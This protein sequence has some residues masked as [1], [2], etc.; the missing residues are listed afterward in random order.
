MQQVTLLYEHM[1]ASAIACMALTTFHSVLN[2]LLSQS[3]AD[4]LCA[5]ALV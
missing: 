4:H 1:Y 2:L 5:D 3:F